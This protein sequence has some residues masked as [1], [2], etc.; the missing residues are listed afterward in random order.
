MMKYFID[1]HDKTKGSFPV[2]ELTEQQFFDQFD[3]LE[4]AAVQ[5]QVV[6]HAAYVNLEDGKAFCFMS[7]PDE[8]SIRKAHAAINLPYDLCVPKIRFCNIDGEGRQGQ[9]VRR[10]R[11]GAQSRDGEG[12]PC[13]EIDGSSTHY[14]RRHIRVGS[15]A[16]ALRQTRSCG[17]DIRGGSSRSVSQR[18]HSARAI[19]VQSDGPECPLHGSAARRLDHTRCLDP[20]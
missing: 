12:R 2:E 6:G 15:G 13:S 17:R 4:K 1:T 7:G 20:A 9:V 8:E 3:A 19:G 18:K 11:R 14:N 5:F 10:R 16:G